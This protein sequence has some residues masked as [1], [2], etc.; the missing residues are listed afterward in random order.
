MKDFLLLY[1]TDYNLIQQATPEQA[2]ANT[3]KW[4]DWLGSIAAQNK[5]ANKGNRLHNSS[6]VVKEDKVVTN[7]PYSDIKESIGG[8]SII[9][10]ASY[11]EAVELAKDCPVLMHGGNVELREI[12][13]M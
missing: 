1:R 8:Y 10:A 3:K 12:D 5:L 4:M 11:D 13:A 6:K 7:G 2:D 9:K